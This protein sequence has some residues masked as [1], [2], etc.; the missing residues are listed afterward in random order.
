MH[1]LKRRKAQVEAFAACAILGDAHE[2]G[3]VAEVVEAKVAV[4][5]G[6]RVADA[7]I[8]LDIGAST[9]FHGAPSKDLSVASGQLSEKQLARKQVSIFE[10]TERVKRG[11]RNLGTLMVRR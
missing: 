4:G 6:G 5:D 9:V 10:G 7:A 1:G 11:G 8:L 2:P 3:T